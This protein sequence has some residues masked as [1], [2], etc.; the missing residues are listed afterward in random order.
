MSGDVSVQH[1]HQAAAL[2]KQPAR[3]PKLKKRRPWRTLATLSIAGGAGLSAARHHCP[4]PTAR[5]DRGQSRRRPERIGL[6]PIGAEGR[7]VF[8]HRGLGH[9]GERRPGQARPVCLGRLEREDAVADALEPYGPRAVPRRKSEGLARAP[10]RRQQH[11][12][13]AGEIPDRDGGTAGAGE[14][15]GPD[16]LRLADQQR[17]GEDRRSDERPRVAG[18]Q[19][20]LGP[21]HVRRVGGD[22]GET[23]GRTARRRKGRP[24]RGRGAAGRRGGRGDVQCVEHP[25]ERCFAPLRP[26]SR[27]GPR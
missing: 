2:D 9:R 11:R 25:A 1:P 7:L 13:P 26:D 6:D 16:R 12:G 27:R 14:D 10:R 4:L 23:L 21:R 17:D 24:A 18:E 8:A 20:R 3:R 5:L 19:A 15:V 22:S